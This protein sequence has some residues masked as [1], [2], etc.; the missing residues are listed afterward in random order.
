MSR[1][2]ERSP[3]SN[4]F[5]TGITDQIRSAWGRLPWPSPGKGEV[6]DPSRGLDIFRSYGTKV[7]R[8]SGEPDP[9]LTRDP[10]AVNQWG[11]AQTWP[12]P[13]GR[14]WPVTLRELGGTAIGVSDM[15]AGYAIVK[16]IQAR[17]FVANAAPWPAYSLYVSE[18]SE[19]EGGNQ[20]LSFIP[21]GTRIFDSL[22]YIVDDATAPAARDGFTL[23]NVTDNQRYDIM[24]PIRLPEFF[25]KLKLTSNN[26][27]DAIHALVTVIEGLTLEQM[28]QLLVSQ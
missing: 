22:D 12:Y 6:D 11:L 21:A 16:S 20:P 18:T 2:S 17:F 8:V 5:K 4:K 7:T 25:L 26:T 27:G 15:M 3:R 14:Q 19:N 23:F 9:G 1:F 24:A 13:R 28:N 10:N